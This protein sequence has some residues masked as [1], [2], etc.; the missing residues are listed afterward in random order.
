MPVII[1]SDVRL[2]FAFLADKAHRTTA[3]GIAGGNQYLFPNS[4]MF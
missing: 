1:P 4:S 2:P 3:A